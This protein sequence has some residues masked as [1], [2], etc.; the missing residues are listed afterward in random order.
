MLK[1]LKTKLIIILNDIRG[2]CEITIKR[3]LTPEQR[4]AFD[5]FIDFL[6]DMVEK[7]SPMLDEM[8]QEQT[9]NKKTA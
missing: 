1:L 3:E 6:A 7:Y 5:R 4:A 9:P 8:R 2:E